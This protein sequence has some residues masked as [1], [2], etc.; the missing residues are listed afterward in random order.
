MSGREYAW[1]HLGGEPRWRSCGSEPTNRQHDRAAC[2]EIGPACLWDMIM[3]G[4][5]LGIEYQLMT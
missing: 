3:V 5:T 4:F 1:D 2:R